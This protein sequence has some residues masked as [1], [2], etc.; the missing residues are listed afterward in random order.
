MLPASPVQIAGSPAAVIGRVTPVAWDPLSGAPRL[1]VGRPGRRAAPQCPLCPQVGRD[2]AAWPWAISSPHPLIAAEEGIHELVANCGPHGRRFVDLTGQEAGS[3]SRDGPRG[4][5]RWG[6]TSGG[7]G[8]TRDRGHQEHGPRGLTGAGVGSNLAA[9]AIP[10]LMPNT[11]L[12]SPMDAARAHAVSSVLNQVMRGLPR[13]PLDAVV[14]IDRPNKAW[15]EIRYHHHP[16]TYV[17]STN[18]LI[19]ERAPDDS[20][21]L[22]PC[23]PRFPS[24]PPDDAT[25]LVP[26]LGVVTRSPAGNVI[27]ASFY[28]TPP[29]L[30][31]NGTIRGSLS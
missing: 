27:T 28:F 25:T 20:L 23:P 16:K 24:P 15:I 14:L 9:P 26:G 10:T 2:P 11:C 1:M 29:H 22:S 17:L 3:R 18:R 13:P 5:P 31:D 4:S 7:C 30:V 21:R 8:P 19:F 12:A 6:A